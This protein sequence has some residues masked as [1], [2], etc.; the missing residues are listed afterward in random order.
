[1]K[2]KGLID[3]VNPTEDV[4][5]QLG[6]QPDNL[7]RPNTPTFSETTITTLLITTI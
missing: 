4:H 7:T 1:M 3:C 6:K 5:T 2:A